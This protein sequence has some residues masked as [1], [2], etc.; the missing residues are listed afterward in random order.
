MHN[1]SNLLINA[2]IMLDY[3]FLLAIFFWYQLFLAERNTFAIITEAIQRQNYTVSLIVGVIL[4]LH[5]Y[6]LWSGRNSRNYLRFPA[7]CKLLWYHQGGSMRIR[8]TIIC[9]L[10][11]TQTRYIGTN[12]GLIYCW[13]TTTAKQ[14][15]WRLNTTNCAKL[16]RIRNSISRRLT[17][18]TLLLPDRP[19]EACFS[20]R[21]W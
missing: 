9:N 16:T 1:F 8:P 12:D 15:Y 10:H 7:R 13:I 4:G 2:L 20:D 14:S 19:R 3:N 21:V 17:L 18:A 11:L 5:V 6:P